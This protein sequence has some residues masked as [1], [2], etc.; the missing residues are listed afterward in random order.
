MKFFSIIEIKTG[1]GKQQRFY[2]ELKGF[3]KK[4]QKKREKK[5][6]NGRNLKITSF[7]FGTE[8]ATY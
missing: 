6:I 8:S 7:I 1:W 5:K 4:K 2:S 3:H